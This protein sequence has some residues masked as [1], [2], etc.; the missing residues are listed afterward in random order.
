[1]KAADDHPPCRDCGSPYGEDCITTGGRPRKA[2]HWWIYDEPLMNPVQ[3][4]AAALL[5]GR[6]LTDAQEAVYRR[7]QS[8]VD[9]IMEAR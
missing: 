8:V 5:A 6:R 9:M 7:S 1:M 2:H 3:Q 4:V